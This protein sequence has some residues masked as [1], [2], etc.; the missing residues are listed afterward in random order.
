M[1]PVLSTVA[2]LGIALRRA[3]TAVDGDALWTVAAI[4]ATVGLSTLDTIAVNV[5]LPT[6]ERDLDAPVTEGAWMVSSFFL[7]VLAFV[8][9]AGRVADQF[10]RRRTLMFGTAVFTGASVRAS[11]VRARRPASAVSCSC[12]CWWWS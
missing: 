11:W 4:A 10:G 7:A 9:V 1:R 5:A 3:R 12:A 2:P 8:I 6:L